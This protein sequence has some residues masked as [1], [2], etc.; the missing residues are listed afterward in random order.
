MNHVAEFLG[1]DLPVLKARHASSKPRRRSSPIATFSYMILHNDT[2]K[3][4]RRKS[5][6]DDTVS[7]VSATDSDSSLSVSGVSFADP[8]VTG[9]ITRPYTSLRDKYS[10]Y[11]SNY[12]FAEFRREASGVESREKVVKFSPTIVSEVWVTPPVKN[13]SSLYY[14]KSDLQG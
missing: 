10:L 14:S 6:D 2:L 5:P 12:D 13:A 4:N 9:V 8:L 1:I 7:T 11:Y 3:G